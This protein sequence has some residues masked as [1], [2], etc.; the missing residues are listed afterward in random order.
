MGAT[1]LA[2]TINRVDYLL[3]EVA[4]NTFFNENFVSIHVTTATY[5]ILKKSYERQSTV[6]NDFKKH[7]SQFYGLGRFVDAD[8]IDVYFEKMNKLRGLLEYDISNLCYE[9]IDSKGRVQFSFATKMLNLMNDEKYPI[10]DANIAKTFNI[11]QRDSK[12]TD[13]KITNYV[14]TYWLIK[15]VY[16]E[17]LPRHTKTIYKFREVFDYSEV[18]LSD[19]RIM[20]I[21]VWKIGEKLLK[22]EIQ[23][24]Y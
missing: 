13:E 1:R 20:D 3:S 24:F 14:N 17:I 9:L 18:E 11:N 21:I 16:S 19:L 6:N 22:K 12:N 4:N 15:D 23:L 2:K 10:Y 7:F 5:L 8:F